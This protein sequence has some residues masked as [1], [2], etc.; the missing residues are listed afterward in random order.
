MLRVLAFGGRA[1]SRTRP[2][3]PAGLARTQLLEPDV[4][5]T[6]RKEGFRPLTVLGIG[7]RVPESIWLLKSKREGRPRKTLICDARTFCGS[8]KEKQHDA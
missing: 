8:R 2:G 3:G 1:L 4:A 6:V 7:T 5:R